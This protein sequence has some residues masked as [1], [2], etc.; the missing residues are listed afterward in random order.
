VLADPVE[1]DEVVAEPVHL[2]E[3]QPGHRREAFRR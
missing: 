1:H 3:P 2:G